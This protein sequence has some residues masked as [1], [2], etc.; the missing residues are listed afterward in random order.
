MKFKLIPGG[1]G[2]GRDDGDDYEPLP[3][4]ESLV[5]ARELLERLYSGPTPFSC[6]DVEPDRCDVSTRAAYGLCD[7][8]GHRAVARFRFGAFVLCRA[9]LRLRRNAEGA[10]RL[11]LVDDLIGRISDP[12]E[13]AA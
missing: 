6:P 7:E 5:L 12:E 11:A 3:R 1:L 8:C 2:H 9:C 4:E 13:P 10:D